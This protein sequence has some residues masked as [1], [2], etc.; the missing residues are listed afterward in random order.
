MIVGS[1]GAD[2]IEGGG[3]NDLICAGS[4]ADVVSGGG[5]DDR[6]LGG[7]GADLLRG[8]AGD[9][10]IEGGKG[11]DRC[12]G[13]G[14]SNRLTSCEKGKSPETTRTNRAPLA[15]DLGHHHRRGQPQVDRGH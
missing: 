13:G 15:K 6:V 7:S 12:L 5:G 11:R 2:R 1:S 4:G 10:R 14:G 3:G 9:D 8:N